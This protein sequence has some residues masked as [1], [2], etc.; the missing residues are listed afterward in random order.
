MPAERDRCC[1]SPGPGRKQRQDLALHC[2]FGGRRQRQRAQPIAWDAFPAAQPR[3]ALE[4]LYRL[5][6]LARDSE[7]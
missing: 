2:D 5:K 6:A 7:K 4:A 1:Q 3:D